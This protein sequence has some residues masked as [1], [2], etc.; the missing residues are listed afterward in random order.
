[1]TLIPYLH[2]LDLNEED[3]RLVKPIAEPTPTREISLVY[4]R[5]ELKIR[6]IGALS[7]VISQ[8]VPARLRQEKNVILSPVPQL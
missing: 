7:E 6:I 2:A 8:S 1:M 3:A 5:A 4:S